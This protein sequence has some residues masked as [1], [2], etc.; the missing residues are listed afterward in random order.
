VLT[1]EEFQK[2]SVLAGAL[3][4]HDEALLN[5]WPCVGLNGHLFLSAQGSDPR[6]QEPGPPGQT[7]IVRLMTGQEVRAYGFGSGVRV[8]LRV[9]AVGGGVLTLMARRQNA[10]GDDALAAAKMI[11][12]Y[13]SAVLSHHHSVSRM[14]E[15]LINTLGDVLDVRE[16]FPRISEVVSAVLPHDRLALTLADGADHF[17][18]H[19]ATSDDAVP[20]AQLRLKVSGL[21]QATA[22][23]F[24]LIGDLAIEYVPVV[25]PA[26]FQA[27]MLAAG[28]RSVLAAHTSTRHHSLALHFWS[29]QP[30]AFSLRDLPLARRVADCIGLALSHQ[31]LANV[32]R[33]IAEQRAKTEQLE[34]RVRSL[35]EEL[36]SRS[37]YGRVIGE[38]AEWK[39]VLKR[40]AQV[41]ETNTTVLLTG[42]SGTGKEVIG[43]S[44]ITHRPGRTHRFS[45][46]IARR[47]PNNF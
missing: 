11:A 37:G 39:G 10:Y 36:D 5:L 47:Y 27:Q 20:V 30:H 2:L 9:T 32:A 13:L 44:S 23:G 31:Q 21:T 3:I 34:L 18:F 38:S 40:A 26:D 28:Y 35:T 45:R 42:E 14:S 46:S 29:K 1:P 19:A 12:D 17:L 8:P 4:P 22:A 6:I 25:E 15:D 41:A 16:V 7:E 24:K 43:V 33:Q